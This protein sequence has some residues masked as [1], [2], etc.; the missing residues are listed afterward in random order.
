MSWPSTD[1]DDDDEEARTR[2]CRRGDSCGHHRRER[3]RARRGSAP[4]VTARPPR[5][6][7][8]SSTRRAMSWAKGSLS[9]RWSTE[10]Q[11]ADGTEPGQGVAGLLAD[12]PGAVTEETADVGGEDLAAVRGRRPLPRRRGPRFV[13]VEQRGD[14]LRGRRRG[15]RAARAAISRRRGSSERAW[16]SIDV[17]AGGGRAASRRPRAPR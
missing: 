14:E 15:V 3:D 1:T 17:R 5:A 10:D 6:S 12:L 9:P 4:G 11:R 2:G 8:S 7:T 16:R 13:V